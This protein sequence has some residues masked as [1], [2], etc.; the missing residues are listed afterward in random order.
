MSSLYGPLPLPAE[1]LL[2]LAYLRILCRELGIRRLQAPS[3][4]FVR[5]QGPEPLLERVQQ[6][7][8]RWK[9]EGDTISGILEGKEPLETLIAMLEAVLE[10]TEATAAP[11]PS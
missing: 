7:R 3:A 4:R 9:H 8:P 2:R 6:H 10:E 1:N 11:A 5:I